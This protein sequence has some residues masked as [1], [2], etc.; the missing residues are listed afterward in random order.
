MNMHLNIRLILSL[1]LL[2]CI[3]FPAST[4]F[5]ENNAGD[6]A[7]LAFRSQKIK[8]AC[9]AI[10]EN[11]NKPANIKKLVKTSILMGYSACPII[12]CSIEG[13][14]NLEQILTGAIEAGVSPDVVS[15]CALI[16]GAKNGD[17]ATI[18]AGAAAP[19][20]CFI[21]PGKQEILTMPD[22]PVISPVRF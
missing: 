18:L 21:I 13:K 10:A 20:I 5:A 17:I 22:V 4:V 8:A 14:G 19:A 1:A 15:K 12:K 3:L 9:A 6:D 16:A 11:I 7:T 2:T